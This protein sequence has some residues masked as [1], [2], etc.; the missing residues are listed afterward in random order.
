MSECRCG[1][2]TL[3]DAGEAVFED[4][5]LVDLTELLEDWSQVGV[6]ERARDLSDE[7]LDGVDVLHRDGMRRCA[8]VLRH[9]LQQVHV[10]GWRLHELRQ[11]AH[12]M[13]VAQ[14]RHVDHLEG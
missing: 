10:A 6:A 11:R 2:L 12:V 1:V 8:H 4:R 7:E 13:S 3:V 9:L 5:Q 14:S